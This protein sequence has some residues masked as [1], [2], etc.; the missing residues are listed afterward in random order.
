MADWMLFRGD[1]ENPHD[2]IDGLPPPPPWRDFVPRDGEALDARRGRT[3]RPF[4]KKSRWSTRRF[5]CAGRCWLPARPA[6]ARAR[7]PT[8]SPTR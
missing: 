6:L 1:S 2:A 8:Q 5:I 3:Y 4:W 7:W